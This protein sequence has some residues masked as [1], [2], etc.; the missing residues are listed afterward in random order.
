MNV[1]GRVM[2]EHNGIEDNPMRRVA[3]KG[4]VTAKER[5]ARN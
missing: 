2:E 3:E 1:W 5:S 4:V